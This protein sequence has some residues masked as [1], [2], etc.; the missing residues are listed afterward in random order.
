MLTYENLVGNQED[1]ANYITNV[2]MRETPFL[3]W[4]EADKNEVR[5]VLY[6]YQAEKFATPTKN[7]H[8][9]GQPWKTFSSVGD[10]RGT[11]KALIQ[12]FDK[13]C[14]IS[15]LSEDVVDVAGIGDQLAR[16]I[17]KKLKEMATDMEVNF[18]ED[19]DCREDNKVDGYLTRGVGSWI[20]NSAQAL[21]PVPSDFR[22]PSA[23]I[24]TTASG[25]M[26]ENKVRDI[27]QSIASTCKSKEPLTAFVGATVKRIFSD[28]QLFMPSST[29]T[30]ANTMNQQAGT[31][32][33]SIQRYEGDFMPVDLVLSYW[34]AA[35]TTAANSPLR[36]YFLH[37]RMWKMRW[38]QKPKVYSPEFQG[39]SYEAAMDALA[40]LVCLNP[41]GEGK[42]APTS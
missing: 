6:Q 36:A 26:T 18:C 12:W 5:N 8:V 1:W 14:S 37:R 30:A 15:K 38:K 25:S 31:I 39:G 40:M 20:S 16:E 27:L 19:W 17:P 3:D 10:G 4:L 21:Y 13:T 34:L 32:D 35:Y 28:F 33:R 23:S 24:D 29:S 41:K 11:L 2:E 42:Y 7:S 22:T 9:D